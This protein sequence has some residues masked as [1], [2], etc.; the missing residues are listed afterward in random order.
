MGINGY[1]GISKQTSAN[2]AE[3]TVL[4]KKSAAE[5]CKLLIERLPSDTTSGKCEKSLSAKTSSE[6]LRAAAEPEDIATEQSA[7]LRASTSFTP[8]PVIVT[9]CPSVCRARTSLRFAAGVTR[10]KM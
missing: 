5:R 6:T 10:P 1:G 4:V 3:Y 2:K 9:Q 7:S 8:S